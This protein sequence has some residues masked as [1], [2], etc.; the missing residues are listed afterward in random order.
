MTI[1]HPPLPNGLTPEKLLRVMLT[2]LAEELSD[3]EL[4]RIIETD[5]RNIRRW[6]DGIHTPRNIW[7][8]ARE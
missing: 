6:R 1:K 7:Q 4:G 3:A 8:I 5:G 2:R